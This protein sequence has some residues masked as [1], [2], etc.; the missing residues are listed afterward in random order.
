LSIKNSLSAGSCCDRCSWPT[1]RHCSSSSAPQSWLSRKFPSLIQES[2]SLKYEP[3]SEPETRNVPHQHH[4]HGF[5]VSSPPNPQTRFRGG[6]VA[7][8]HRRLYHSTLGL[9]VIK[10]ERERR[11]SSSSS[12]PRSWFSRK[13]PLPNFFF[14]IILEPGVE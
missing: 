6:L 2:M 1:S 3:V 9:R 13:T 4:N 11:E 14:F 5:R 8:A 7:K 10:R 12:A